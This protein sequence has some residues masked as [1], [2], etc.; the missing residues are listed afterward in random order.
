MSSRE[1][2]IQEEW[3]IGMLLFVFIDVTHGLVGDGIG[4]EVGFGFVLGIGIRRD[5]LVIA[6]QRERII[7]TASTADHPVE[8]IEATRCKGQLCL[9]PSFLMFS[10]TCHLPAA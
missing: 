3:F 8:T 9:G 7:E 10:V 5:Q 2:D 6:A 4:K 1:R